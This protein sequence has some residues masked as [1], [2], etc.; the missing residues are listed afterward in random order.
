MTS[1]FLLNIF[2]FR[3]SFY[4]NVLGYSPTLTAEASRIEQSIKI[5]VISDLN[6][7]RIAEY[8]QRANN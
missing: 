8:T 1:K 2:K 3:F 4:I 5:K 7:I 6:L